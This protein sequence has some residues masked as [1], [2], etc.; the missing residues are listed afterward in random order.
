MKEEW[1]KAQQE[2]EE[3]LSLFAGKLKYYFINRNAEYNAILNH[4]VNRQ[5]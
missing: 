3:A 5:M 1:N 2:T 4:M